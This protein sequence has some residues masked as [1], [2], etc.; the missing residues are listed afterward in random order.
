MTNNPLRDSVIRALTTP[1]LTKDGAA[2]LGKALHPSDAILPVN[3]IP[4]M[5][6]VPTAA[7]NFMTTVNVGA[8][9]LNTWNAHIRLN[10][11]PL[12]F[13]R[14]HTFDGTV[15][16]STC[17]YNPSL[18]VTAA[19]SDF[20]AA[21]RTWN[22]AAVAAWSGNT[23]K[24]RLIYASMTVT[25]SASTTTDQGSV[26]VAQYPQ[27]YNT[28]LA[29]QQ[30]AIA[31]PSGVGSIKGR[32]YTT[33]LTNWATSQQLQSMAGAVT[34]EARKGVYTIL[35]L[36]AQNTWNRST[37]TKWVAGGAAVTDPADLSAFDPVS[38]AY[39]YPAA[40]AAA[41]THDPLFG[42]TGVWIKG[43]KAGSG[44]TT[45]Y[46]LTGAAGY[47]P[48]Q[49]TLSHI[50]FTGLNGEAQLTITVRYGVE[51]VVQPQSIYV[52]QVGAPVQYDPIALGVYYNVSREMMAGYPA[53]YNVFGAILGALK[54]VA[55]AAI[56]WVGRKIAGLIDPPAKSQ[57]PQMATNYVANPPNRN[58]P[59]PS[60]DGYYTEEQERRRKRRPKPK[61]QQPRRRPRAARPAR[62][63]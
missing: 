45:A 14:V 36:D 26:T 37:G 56:P 47:V 59:E 41:T 19:F 10:P 34:W 63:R 12:V 52:G 53:D 43:A 48:D 7:L 57:P 4:T 15:A 21:A 32:S 60:D 3:G 20:G 40:A 27:R 1:G 58:R 30:Y 6:S 62:R 54:N 61:Q 25:L 23:V 9:A 11:S 29:Y 13:G 16:G 17:I 50:C 28:N 22:T 31:T 33:A 46:T 18:G 24:Y 39:D 51:A 49:D 8:P 35:K 42:Q 44:A 2:W 55:G 38:G 5:D